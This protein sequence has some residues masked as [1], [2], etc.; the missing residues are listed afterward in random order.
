MQSP[1]QIEQQGGNPLVGAALAESRYPVMCSALVFGELKHDPLTGG[2][3]PHHEL[4]HALVID[5][6][7]MCI[8][9]AFDRVWLAL[10][11][12][13]LDAHQITGQEN[14]DDLPTAVLDQAG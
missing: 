13:A 4:Q 7:H 9:Q 5:R 8:C 1:A 6:A 10:K 3:I 2:M 14:N 12:H 11:Q